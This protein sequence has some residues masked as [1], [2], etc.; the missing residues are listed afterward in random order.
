M[1]SAFD[2]EKV[3]ECM[4]NPDASE[5]LAELEDGGKEL[6]YLSKKLQISENE[7]RERI[8]YLLE[9]DFVKEE[10]NNDKIIFSADADKLAKIIEQD[11]NFDGVVDG[12]AEMDSYLN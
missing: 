2:K 9:H 8:S 7:I 4:F 6:T 11:K 12:L 10:K 3:L 1:D 5:I